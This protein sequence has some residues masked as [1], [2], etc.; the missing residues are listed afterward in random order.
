MLSCLKKISAPAPP[1]ADSV[2]ESKATAVETRPDSEDTVNQ[3]LVSSSISSTTDSL[4]LVT[5]REDT[6]TEDELDGDA[7]L[8]K[9]PKVE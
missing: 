4:S 2:V 3:R 9:R 5:S 6:T 1:E 7:V 8:L